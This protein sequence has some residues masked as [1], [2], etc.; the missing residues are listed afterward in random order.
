[1]LIYCY[2][3]LCA[4]SFMCRSARRAM[5][6]ALT[7]A[8][9]ARIEKIDRT[10]FVCY[11][12]AKESDLA[13]ETN[14]SCVTK[15]S[16]EIGGGCNSSVSETAPSRKRGVGQRA[17]SAHGETQTETETETGGLPSSPVTKRR[18]GRPPRQIPSASPTASAR[19]EA[20]ATDRSATPS[21][22]SQR[23]NAMRSKS[24]KNT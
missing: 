15:T 2:P 24:S 10:H 8:S 17:D 16:A 9:P 11:V 7:G 14:G 6:A 21:R 22:R 3:Y 5:K 4:L 23:K 1:M 13:D 12:D 18:R 20:R 19:P